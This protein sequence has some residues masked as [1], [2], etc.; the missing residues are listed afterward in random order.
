MAEH[1][2]NFTTSQNQLTPSC[3]ISDHPQRLNPHVMKLLGSGKTNTVLA[4]VV[5]GLVSAEE[6]ITKNDKWASRLR[7][8]HA[9]KGR[10][11]ATTSL[12]NVVV[13]ANG[14]VGTSEGKGKVRKTITLLTFNGILTSKAALGTD[15]LIQEFCNGGWHGEKRSA[16]V[17]NSAHVHFGSVTTKGDGFQSNFPVGLAANGE[18]GNLASVVGRVGAIKNSLGLGSGVSK[19]KSKDWLIEQTLPDHG[20]EWRLNLVDGNGVITETQDS[21]KAAKG[22][23]E[24]RL[25]CD[26][27]KQL[28]LEGQIP[29]SK[30]IL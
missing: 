23:C 1:D 22:K 16:S 6:R 14:K 21:V 4:Q 3:T 10:D 24:S 13:W 12:E 29:N 26:F 19:V 18:V 2:S 11:T 30:S 9:S 28:I 8:V 7:N 15:L 17:E 5:D 20:I 25:V 27:G